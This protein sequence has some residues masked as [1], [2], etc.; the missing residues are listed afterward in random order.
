LR[1]RY[2][3]DGGLAKPGFQVDNITVGGNSVGTAE[4]NEGWAFDGF[5]I[6]TGS[7]IQEFANY[8]VAENRGYVGY[9]KSLKTA[10]NFGFLN[11]RPNWVESFPYQD[12][13]LINYWDTSQ[14]DNNVGD[15]P[16]EGLV[17]PIDAHPR[18]S[19]SY[20]GELLRPRISSYDS[21][22][23]LDRV[24][25]ITVHKDS[26]ATTIPA[27]PAKKVFDDRRDYWFAVDAHS[28]SDG[29]VGRYQ[30]GWYGVKVPKTGTLVR[31]QSIN[32]NGVMRVHVA[33]AK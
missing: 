3:T 26:K 21:T 5:R 15:H 16:G 17:L 10:Y 4:G 29:H 6:T 18:F 22:F 27:R 11:K 25:S 20:D 30:P 9:D 23:G 12:G 24:Q 32:S 7:E 31:I 13:L 1:F 33:P 8:Y 14:T 2:Q 19:H 28:D